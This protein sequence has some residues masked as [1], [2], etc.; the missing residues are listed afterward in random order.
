MAQESTSQPPAGGRGN[1]KGKRAFTRRPQA[2]LESSLGPV[3][4]LSAGGMRIIAKRELKG[5]V[6]VSLNGGGID[7]TVRAR[8]IWTKKISFRVYEVGL[9][10]VDAR[11]VRQLVEWL[12]KWGTPNT[13]A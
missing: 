9:A 11:E 8:V 5:V 10:F 4:D 13:A 1:A 2:S 3:L 6:D 12:S 7:Q